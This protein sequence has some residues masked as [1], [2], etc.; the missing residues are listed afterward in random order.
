MCCIQA[1]LA[2]SLID[3]E[4]Q[5][6]RDRRDLAD[7][8]AAIALSVQIEQQRLERNMELQIEQALKEEQ[9][10]LDTAAAAEA[11]AKAEADAAAAIE[12]SMMAK[13]SVQAVDAVEQKYDVPPAPAPEPVKVAPAPVVA[14]SSLSLLGNLPVI[15]PVKA[16]LPVEK[17]IQFSE[18]LE[19]ETEALAKRAAQEFENNA[20]AVKQNQPKL[21]DD[22]RAR[23][24]EF[25]RA[26]RDKLLAQKRAQR[27]EE[28]AFMN[29][30]RARLQSERE[31]LSEA[32]QRN[33]AAALDSAV[34]RLQAQPAPHKASEPAPPPKQDDT[35]SRMSMRQALAQRFKNDMLQKQAVVWF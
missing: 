9:A 5:A 35:A 24:Q 2:A 29:A 13:Q 18:T 3:A 6:A 15:K 33:A 31:A 17:L 30:E 7:M 25:L 1:A 14:A 27:L 12:S 4:L 8:E 34:S 10:K 19:A 11:T 28:E 21:S 16:S 23:R 26:Q 22:E 20:I 32:M